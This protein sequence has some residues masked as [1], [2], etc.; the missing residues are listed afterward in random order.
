LAEKKIPD[1]IKDNV[2]SA[3][4]GGFGISQNEV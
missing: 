2:E 1:F 4:L 3:R